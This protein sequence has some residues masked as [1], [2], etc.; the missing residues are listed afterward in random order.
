M[1]TCNTVNRV[2]LSSCYTFF[3]VEIKLSFTL[4]WALTYMYCFDVLLELETIDPM[5][6]THQLMV[7]KE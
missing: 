4:I 3:Y 7:I 5:P 1:A 2:Q 6:A